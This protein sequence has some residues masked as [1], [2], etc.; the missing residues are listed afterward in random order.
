MAS[1]HTNEELRSAKLH[2]EE[3]RTK[4]FSIGKKEPNPLTLD[5]HHAVTSLSAEL[6]Q[7]DIHFLMELIQNAEDNEYKEGV[8]PT[9]E[10]VLTKKDI[11]GSGAPA[12]LLVFNNEVG[13]SR[14]NID[15]ICSIGRSTK[16]GKRQQGFIGEK[17]IGFKSVF[18]VSSQPHIFSNGYRVRFMEEP[19]QDCGIG[20]IVPEYVSGVS[21]LLS[22]YDVYGVNKI[23]PTTTFILPLKPDKVE[24]VRAQLS[25][26][27]PEILLFLSKVKRL[28][29]RGF[30]PE[31]ADDVST[32]SIF[33]ETEQK[34]LSNKRA[35]SRVVT[36][37][38][39]EKKC[40][41]EELCKYYLWRE[42]FPVNPTNR[43][44]IRT[45]V[46]EWV[47]TLAFPFGERLRRGTSSV[48]IFAFLPT[49]MVTNFPFVIQA[50]FI[51]ASSRES[52]MLDNVWNL[53][54]LDCVPSAFVNAFQSC[55]R[56]LSFFPSVDQAFQFLPAQPS[57]IPVFN[58]LREA[59]RTRVQGLQIVPC[60]M[61]SGMSCLFLKPQHAVRILPKF[62]D[63]VLRMKN[64]GAIS[65]NS[66]SLKK[67]LHSSLDL[68][69]YS[70][71]LDFLDV[72]S[73][74]G[75]W[76]TKCIK[77][78]SLVLLSDVVYV[79]LLCF[80]VDNEKKFS[81]HIKTLPLIKYINC[82]GNLALCTIANT[83]TETPKVRYAMDLELHTWLSKCNMEFGC[84][85]VY[86][87][88]NRTQKALLNNQKSEKIKNSGIYRSS[89]L[90]NWLDQ[91]GVI[92]CSAD[93][94]VSLLQNHVSGKE[95]N[96]AVTLSNFLYHTHR[97]GFLADY[98]ISDIC[99]RIPVIDGADHV[100]MQR[101]VTLVPAL[102]SEWMKLFG[103]QN[104]F[105]EQNFVD[106]GHVYSKSSLFLGESTPE[107][108]LLRFICKHSKAVDLPEL[109]PPD[110][111]L[112]IASHELSSEQA[113][114][115]LDW[116]RLLRTKG[117]RLPL[118]FIE[119]IR[120]G[121]WIKTYSGYISPRKAILP[122][123]TGKA[124][125]DMMKHVLKVGSILDL[126]FY[127]N[128][129]DLYQDELK[130]L[131]V[132]LG[133]DDVRRLVKNW[134]SSIAS[135]GMSKMCV[136]SLLRFIK[137]CRRRN[138][139][140]EDWL[141]V[142]KDK[143]W[144]K[145]HQG[146]NAPKGSI[147]LPSEIEA[148]TCLKITNLPII[149]RAFYRSILGSFLSELKLL[150]VTYGLEEVQKS[151]LENM[152]LTSNLSSLTGGCGLLILQCIRCLGSEAA[153]LIIR[154]KCKPWIKTTLGF[155]TP[156][157]TVL[158]DQRWGA[159]FTA[160]QVPVIEESYYGN[161]IRDFTDELNVVGVVVDNV[162]ATQ[163]IGAQFN[164]LL[165]SSS[166]APATVMSLLGCIRELTQ[167]VLLQCYELKWLLCEN[168]LKTRHGYKTP[169]E[170]ILFSSKW[171]SILL[172]VDLP[173][174]DDA[175]YGTGIYKFKDELRM[176]GVITDFEQ[177]APFVAKGLH[178]P[179]Q[180]ELI[181]ADGMISLLECIKHL[182]SR[183]DDEPLLGDLRQNFAESRCLK[184]MKGYKIPQECVLFDPEWES[185]L[186]RSDAPSI[187]E[188]FYGTSIY[189]YKNQLRDIGVKV[190]PLDVC[191]LISGLLLSLSDKGLI[192]RIYGFMNKLQWN[193][194]V[195]DKCN[196]QVW[197]PNSKGTGVWVKSQFCVLHD[198]KNLFSS[199][200]FCLEKFYK[201][202]LLPFFSSAFGVAENPSIDDYLQLWNSW[203]L[204]DNSQVTVAEC[205]SFWEFV[206]GN[207]NQ[208]VE[209]TLKQNLTKL[210]ATV[211]TVDEPYL[212]SREEVFIADDLQL[213]KIFSSSNK[214]PLFVWIPKSI[215]E[216]YITPRRL[217]AIYEIF[218]VRKMSESVECNVSGMLSLE[219]CEKV[220][221][222]ERLIGRGLIKIILGFLAG[223]EVNMPVKERH[224]V[225]RSI[226]VLSVY[227]SDNPIKVCY[228]LK[229]SASTT[230]EVEKLKLVL[231]EKNS[232]HLLIDESGYEDG[233]D[234]LEFVTS[235][236][237]EL[238][239]GLLA[240]VRPTAADALSKIIQL[241]YVFDFND[242]EVE[243]LLMK[244]NAELLVEDVKFLDSAFPLSG[245]TTVTAVYRK[246]AHKKLEQLGPSTPMP[247]CK[248]QRQ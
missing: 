96:L 103:P 10:F 122:D 204:R 22:I 97:K 240:Q 19:N 133:S 117:A 191:S 67:V 69:K 185:I 189:L 21:F 41:T 205:S 136:F 181:D 194:K 198:R 118:K 127:M 75:D 162:G 184:T 89:S 166:L 235:F 214:V 206:V 94:Y 61:F 119:S 193:P 147:L 167:T 76:Y 219:H 1:S 17:G 134:L 15:S 14:K 148:E 56:E 63:L 9:L 12:T 110:V 53:G 220:D 150:G 228:Q 161:A 135:L 37:S 57:A 128:R 112:Q 177:G 49:A 171:G 145:T 11:T 34:D 13:F 85:G 213:K 164:S 43:V 116:I 207:W 173:L 92:S 199:R 68:E 149:D 142:L 80:I 242:N 44:G 129:I 23:L 195:E 120:D 172:F 72:A 174:I 153:G 229:P 45:D 87:L 114:L 187:D 55:V 234:D 143:K 160:L 6:Y 140:D 163:L 151:I 159:L 248:K 81:N 222:R 230:V 29:V 231:W 50:D 38:V 211:D 66:S 155:K 82:E 243:F 246:R 216:C 111:V 176:L 212:V 115:L 124:I 74:G 98:S 170:S 215:S 27:H 86:F 210:P 223:P 4:K 48:G 105:V 227:K 141:A 123:E 28:Y 60:Q 7:K 24:A 178:S 244:E 201:K 132:G 47:I 31:E 62:R 224:E 109:C 32:I 42:A 197:I 83:K 208:Q 217:H 8:E 241:G 79:E 237:D 101:T 25:E 91:A 3:I 179:I 26:L 100:R 182:R 64:E 126:K 202:E 95:P 39:K 236:A 247:A 169:G 51:L 108:E 218:G 84:P 196:S 36:L 203:A 93:T 183:S 158:P 106:I 33:S 226:V 239:R 175:H 90:C 156:P 190:D 54:I 104:P 78:C 138:M 71:V 59:I 131:G 99:R 2:I 107:K 121:K 73:S 154:I 152:S 200:L 188:S 192:T 221:P 165:S 16:K 125:T 225:A 46:E 144:L 146:Y 58:N 88:P 52:I 180:P 137:F 245:E 5:L 102:D 233:K 139:I 130:F 186:K 209:D 70:A 18:L 30:D 157:E 65:R 238:A 168:W 77:S 35:N 232:P 113:F 40:D 20:Y